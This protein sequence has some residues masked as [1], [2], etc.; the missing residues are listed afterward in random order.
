M[1][2][3]TKDALD[4]RGVGGNEFHT[5]SILEAIKQ[6]KTRMLCSVQFPALPPSEIDNSGT[7]C[8][9]NED[10][11]LENVLESIIPDELTNDEPI[12][13]ASNALM[14][15]RTR[16]IQESLLSSRRLRMGYHHGRLQVISPTWTFPKMSVKQ[17]VDNWYV[18]NK[19]E[20]VPPLKLLDPLHVQ[21][22]GTGV[23]KN[24]GQ[25]RL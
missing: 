24:A 4:E 17:L 5:N 19:K 8:I 23:S 1:K 16:T 10:T 3:D 9:T 7:L 6:S 15:N 11:A 21:Y 2:T 14:N 12:Q 18:G 13:E 20:S 25:A 22:I